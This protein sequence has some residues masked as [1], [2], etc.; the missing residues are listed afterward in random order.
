MNDQPPSS[1]SV[2]LAPPCPRPTRALASPP[3]CPG[4]GARVSPGLV[5]QRTRSPCP[6][7]CPSPRLLRSGRRAYVPGGLHA[8]RQVAPYQIKLDKGTSSTRP[9]TRT[10]SSARPESATVRTRRH[11]THMA[12]RGKMASSIERLHVCAVYGFVVAWRETRARPQGASCMCHAAPMSAARVRTNL[13]VCRAAVSR[14]RLLRMQVRC[15]GIAPQCR[16]A[17]SANGMRSAGGRQTATT[18]RNR[19]QGERSEGG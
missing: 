12:S 6:L 14:S 10:T 3:P 7:R 19:R 1:E 17:W 18:R 2:F 15:E 4:L 5:W 13:A 16:I 9:P 11:V 8:A